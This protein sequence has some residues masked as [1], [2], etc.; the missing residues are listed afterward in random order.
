[1][2]ADGWVYPCDSVVLNKTANHQFGSRW[3]IC[4]WDKVADLMENPKNYYMP[5]GICPGC[6]FADQVDMIYDV[7]NGMETQLPSGSV[8]HVNFV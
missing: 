4:R 1:M 2:N 5:D 8:Q 3:R 7:V 6:V